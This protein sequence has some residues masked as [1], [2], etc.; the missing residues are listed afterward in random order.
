MTSDLICMPTP[1]LLSHELHSAHSELQDKGHAWLA[2]QARS[3]CRAGQLAAFTEGCCT[4][5]LS[6]NCTPSPQVCE[7]G[8]YSD[9]ALTTHAVGH[10]WML[11]ARLSTKDG[12]EEPAC[13]TSVTTVLR[14]VCL[15]PPQEDEHFSHA[16]QID[17]EQRHAFEKPTAKSQVRDVKNAVGVTM[18]RR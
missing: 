6:L 5:V 4:T 14:R 11:H 9:Q 17:T 2:V 7:Q 10:G 16:L 18:L 12:Q 3:S 13:W 15:P 8:V 1:Q